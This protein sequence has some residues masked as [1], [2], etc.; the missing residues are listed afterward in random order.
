MRGPPPTAYG[1]EKPGSPTGG[2]GGDGAGAVPGAVGPGAPEGAGA[3]ADG[4]ELDAGAVPAAAAVGD[5]GTGFGSVATI[6]GDGWIPA[7]P[8]KPTTELR[9]AIAR[10]S[11]GWISAG[12]NW[13]I[14]EANCAA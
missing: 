10:A 1:N 5:S 3:G 12:A 11:A 4:D 14:V 8:A 9:L 13:P 6:S 2:G 7:R